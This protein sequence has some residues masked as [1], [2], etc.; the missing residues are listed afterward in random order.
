MAKEWPTLSSRKEGRKEARSSLLMK[1]RRFRRGLSL[2]SLTGFCWSH[3]SP[4]RAKQMKEDE[5]WGEEEEAF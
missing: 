3:W 2:A 1:G 4:V 5:D